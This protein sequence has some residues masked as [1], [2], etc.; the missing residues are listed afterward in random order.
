[1]PRERKDVERGLQ[2]WR[3]RIIDR[4]AAVAHCLDVAAGD[5]ED[6]ASGADGFERAVDLVAGPDDG[7]T[8]ANPAN[9]ALLHD[10][11]CLHRAD[12]RPCA[13]EHALG[14]RLHSG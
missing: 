11:K 12:L 9:R 3:L 5:D 13:V 14:R 6:R 7:E 1:M 10:I 8:H 4:T 2:Q